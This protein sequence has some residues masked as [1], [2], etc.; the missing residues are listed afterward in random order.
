MTKVQLYKKELAELLADI[1]DP[2]IMKLFLTD[3]FTYAEYED[4]GL[5]LQIIKMLETGTPQR[6]IAKDLGVG[7]ATVTRGSTMLKNTKGGF[8]KILGSYYE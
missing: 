4:F 6:K 7:V 1:D 2:K 8:K 5:R 3:L